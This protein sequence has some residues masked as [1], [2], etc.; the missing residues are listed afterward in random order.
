MRCAYHRQC[1]TLVEVGLGGACYKREKYEK[2]VPGLRYQG[3]KQPVTSPTS[4]SEGQARPR[5]DL[6]ATFITLPSPLTNWERLCGWWSSSGGWTGHQGLWACHFL[7]LECPPPLVHPPVNSQTYFNSYFI[8][9]FLGK[10]FPD[11]HTPTLPRKSV[12]S[13]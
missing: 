8:C 3:R 13:E 5:L 2:N 4:A 7:C 12:T 6:K 10:I 1:K 11:L 9:Y